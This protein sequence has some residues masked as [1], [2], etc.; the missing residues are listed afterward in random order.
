M[1]AEMERELRTSNKRK[2]KNMI[3]KWKQEK[4][5]FS[6]FVMGDRQLEEKFQDLFSKYQ[7]N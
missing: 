7:L 5:K 1:L 6:N 3:F 4:E 2:M